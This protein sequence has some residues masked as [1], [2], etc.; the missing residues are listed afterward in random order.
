MELRRPA[1]QPLQGLQHSSLRGR[2]M[3][4]ASTALS[5]HT[6]P[7]QA[8]ARLILCSQPVMCSGPPS[9][10]ARLLNQGAGASRVRRTAVC[11][12]G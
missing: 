7:A 12:G 10:G 6:A 9:L 1:C 3:L 8:Q 11:G 2:I 4:A 5:R